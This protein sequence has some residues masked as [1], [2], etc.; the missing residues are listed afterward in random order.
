MK[1]KYD[2]KRSDIE[3]L[4]TTLDG[5]I[6]IIRD[7]I[8]DLG[9]VDPANDMSAAGRVQEQEYIQYVRTLDNYESQIAVL[10][11]IRR[12]LV[13]FLNQ[14]DE[15]VG[16]KEEKFVFEEDIVNPLLKDLTDLI[17]D[18]KTYNSIVKEDN[19]FDLW[20][21]GAKS[22]IGEAMLNLEEAG[23]RRS[24]YNYDRKILD[25]LNDTLHR[26]ITTVE[27]LMGE[28][29]DDYHLYF[30]PLEGE[31]LIDTIVNSLNLTIDL[32]I[33]DFADSIGAYKTGSILKSDI[34]GGG[35]GFEYD[36]YKYILSNGKAVTFGITLDEEGGIMLKVLND[37]NDADIYLMQHHYADEF[38]QGVIKEFKRMYPE[39][40]GMT[41][42]EIIW[43]L[44]P[45]TKGAGY[46]YYEFVLEIQVHAGAYNL[47]IKQSSSHETDITSNYERGESSLGPISGETEQEFWDDMESSIL[48]KGVSVGGSVVGGIEET[49]NN[50]NIPSMVE[51]V[52]KLNKETQKYLDEGNTLMFS[53]ILASMTVDE[54]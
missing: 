25:D 43:Y 52:S 38:A 40:S 24:A 10:E 51:H 36:E 12:G 45:E 13:E 6:N 33:Q 54:A 19:G 39:C 26:G 49:Y 20:E 3:D 17:E 32:N 18:R 50:S 28:I 2:F 35:N 9:H 46:G 15:N 11:E 44:F 47:G 4:I 29:N 30:F 14:I 34:D 7:D 48:G 41:D 8:V 5:S 22:Q 1:N 27:S 23:K 53:K 42:D 21:I 37:V 16:L 31:E